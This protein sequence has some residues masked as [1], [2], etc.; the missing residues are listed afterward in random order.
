MVLITSKVILDATVPY[1]WSQKPVMAD[2]DP[3]V[4]KKVMARW[5]EYG[6]D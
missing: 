1:E 6:I 4:V 5:A 2:L 3:E